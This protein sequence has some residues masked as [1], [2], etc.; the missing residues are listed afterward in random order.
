MAAKSTASLAANLSRFSGSMYS[1]TPIDSTYSTGLSSI[2]AGFAPAHLSRTVTGVLMPYLFSANTS[3]SL[4]SGGTS[5]VT[6]RVSLVVTARALGFSLPTPFTRVRTAVT[7]ASGLDLTMYLIVTCLVL[8]LLPLAG[9]NT[10]TTGGNTR[11]MSDTTWTAVGAEL[12]TTSSSAAD[13]AMTGAGDLSGIG[14]GTATTGLGATGFSTGAG[15]VATGGFAGGATTD[16]P[17]PSATAASLKASVSS[18][19]P[20]MPAITSG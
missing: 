18:A 5:T 17:S 7:G 8:T 13:A 2:G 11:V 15:A 20:M 3:T 1:D 4:S 14:A 10:V 16:A 9:D 19:L 12:S 6:S